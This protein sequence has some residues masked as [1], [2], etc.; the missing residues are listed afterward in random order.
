[1]EYR[2]VRQFKE[3]IENIQNGNWTDAAKN[4]VKYGFY[5]TDIIKM[6]DEF[7]NWN[8]DKNDLIELVEGITKKRSKQGLL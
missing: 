4:G 2:T 7:E 6:L 1:M 3:M 5:A 8:I